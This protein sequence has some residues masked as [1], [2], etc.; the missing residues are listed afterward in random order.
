MSYEVYTYIFICKCVCVLQK[1]VN[2]YI[3]HDNDKNN[4][5]RLSNNKNKNNNINIKIDSYN[6]NNTYNNNIII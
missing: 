4:V 2:N 6:Y 3:H 5:S 1:C